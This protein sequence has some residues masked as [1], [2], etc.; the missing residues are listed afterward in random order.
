MNLEKAIERRKKN[1]ERKKEKRWELKK[2]H[3]CIW[4]KVKVKPIITYPQF[5]EEHNPTNRRKRK[6]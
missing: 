1:N 5:C 4:C 2:Q 6:K 3:K